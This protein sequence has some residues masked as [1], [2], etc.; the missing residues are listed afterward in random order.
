MIHPSCQGRCTQSVF[1]A[2][3]PMS[4]VRRKRPQPASKQQLQSTSHERAAKDEENGSAR[5]DRFIGEARF[6]FGLS[7][8]TPETFPTD[9]RRQVRTQ[10]SSSHRP[11][12]EPVQELVR[13]KAEHRSDSTEQE[14]LNILIRFFFA[15]V[16]CAKLFPR[17][18]LISPNKGS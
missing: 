3:I 18:H 17:N 16:P 5:C 11:K 8:A 12:A 4:G 9:A 1:L 6:D 15:F 7:V 14:E 10:L 13:A 2:T